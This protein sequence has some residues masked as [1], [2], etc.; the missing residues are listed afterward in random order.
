MFISLWWGSWLISGFL[1]S[2]GRFM[3]FGAEKAD[4]L[5]ILSRYRLAYDVI[6]LACAALAITVVLRI[7]ARQEDAN[8][9]NSLTE[10][11]R[12]PEPQI[13]TDQL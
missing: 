10:A 5:L 1:D 6:S 13:V 8:R 4:Q 2:F 7:N 3:I 11:R 9:V 12:A